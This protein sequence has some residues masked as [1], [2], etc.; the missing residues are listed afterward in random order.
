MDLLTILEFP[1]PRLRLK[2]EPVSNVTSEV[3][4]LCDAM[5]E[6]MYQAPGIGLA[7]TQVNVQK[8]ILVC[9]VSED[10][11]EPLVLINPEIETAIKKCFVHQENDKHILDPCT[12]IT[13]YSRHQHLYY[14]SPPARQPS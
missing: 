3:T 7:A 9:D 13:Y 12:E 4:A 8:R 6:T 5:L 2:A 10:K 1:D 11:S 14:H